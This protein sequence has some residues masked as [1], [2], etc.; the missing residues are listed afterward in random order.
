MT[1]PVTVVSGLSYLNGMTV[2]ILADGNVM[3][4]QVVS[5]GQITLQ[6]PA[7]SVVVG[8]PFTCQL[9][10]LA[11]DTGEGGPGGSIAG[12][13]KKIGAVTVRVKDTR[14]VQAGRTVATCVPVKAWNSNVW[15][16][17]PLPLVTGD[18]R[19]VLDPQYDTAGQLWLQVTDPVPCT[20]LGVVPELV[21]A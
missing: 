20:V 16:G 10:T 2:S 19:I 6:T 3:A 8:L 21:N 13:M 4:Q 1:A 15:L 18:E 12:K 17:G 14:G 9:Q 5:G 7:S 11:V